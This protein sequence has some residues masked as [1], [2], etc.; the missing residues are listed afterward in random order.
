MMLP[1]DGSPHFVHPPMLPSAVGA[2]DSP[3]FFHPLMIQHQ[4]ERDALFAAY[5]HPPM[6]PGEWN[7]H[8]HSEYDS[9]AMVSF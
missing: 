6:L 9:N 4:D 3:M 2:E 8:G 7:M 5:L 1:G